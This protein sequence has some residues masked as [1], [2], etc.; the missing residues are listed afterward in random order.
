M[1]AP[2]ASSWARVP[3]CSCSSGWPTPS[4]TATG[5]TPCCSA[6]AAPATARARASPPRTRSASG[7]RSSARGRARGSSRRAA[8]AVEAHGTSTRVGDA[9]ELESLGEVFGRSGVEPG[10]IALG[11][12]KSNIGHLKAAAG[13]AG[14]FKMVM[15]L[16]ERVLVAEP[17]LPRAQPQRGLG[18]PPV[19]GQRRAPGLAGRP[20]R[21]APRRRQRVRLRRHELPRGARGV[22]PRPAPRRVRAQELRLGRR[23]RRSGVLDPG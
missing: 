2:T 12:V 7:S 5:S 22:R 21:R 13:A 18:S 1:R 15:Q 17:G 14:L 19:L 3:R 16:Q 8:S 10:S 11:S 6:S 20:R 23:A 9:V 4:A